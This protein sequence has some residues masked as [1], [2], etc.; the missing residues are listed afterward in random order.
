M[1]NRTR[2]GGKDRVREK[3]R[4]EVKRKG[5]K[6]EEKRSRGEIRYREEWVYWPYKKE[7]YG[8]R[9]NGR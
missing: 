8:E 4:N 5:E 3:R 7:S 6:C 2:R 9:E 1:V